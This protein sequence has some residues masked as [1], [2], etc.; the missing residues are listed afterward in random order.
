MDASIDPAI[1]E[2]DFKK[3]LKVSLG[4]H[5]ILAVFLIFRATFF[6]PEPIKIENAIRV[7]IVGLPDKQ[8]KLP[9]IE[10]VPEAKPT[11]SKPAEQPLSE[12]KP[13]L[14]DKPAPAPVIKPRNVKAEQQS[15]IKRLEALNKLKQK[16]EAEGYKIRK[17]KQSGNCYE[18]YGTNSQGQDVEIY[19][20]PVDGKIKKE[21][22]K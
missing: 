19:F 18:I 8:A 3:A 4:G 16:M 21:K 2:Q 11:E 10:P 20:D 17:F 12:T 13:K 7:D 22:K 14:P 5:I 6:P 1:Q 15:A 9:D